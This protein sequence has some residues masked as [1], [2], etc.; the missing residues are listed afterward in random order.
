MN[1]LKVIATILSHFS[2]LTIIKE[3]GVILVELIKK[4]VNKIMKILSNNRVKNMY[5]VIKIVSFWSPN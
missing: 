1:P 4:R 5:L 2:L 3:E